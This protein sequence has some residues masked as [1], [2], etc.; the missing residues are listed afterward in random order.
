MDEEKEV[1]HEADERSSQQSKIRVSV[2][3]LRKIKQNFTGDLADLSVGVPE[4]DVLVRKGSQELKKST[5][6]AP[7]MSKSGIKS[8]Y[9]AE[10]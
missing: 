9:E 6:E 8:V 7:M 1:I 2:S 10:E 4:P 3:S 5:I